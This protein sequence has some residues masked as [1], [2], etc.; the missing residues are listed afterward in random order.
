MWDSASILIHYL[1]IW[2]RCPLCPFRP[3][4][5]FL[6]SLPFP[7]IFFVLV[8]QRW[9]LLDFFKAL[10]R[11]C[12]SRFLTTHRVC[13]HGVEVRLAFSSV[14]IR[15]SAISYWTRTTSLLLVTF[16]IRRIIQRDWHLWSVMANTLA[17]DLFPRVSRLSTF[18]LMRSYTNATR[19]RDVRLWVWTNSTLTRDGP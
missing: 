1:V 15:R 16:R 5:L 19:A 7:S 14:S 13:S 12:G 3:L 11:R 18:S 8:F 2:S 10:A 17:S 4:L 9:A 6:P